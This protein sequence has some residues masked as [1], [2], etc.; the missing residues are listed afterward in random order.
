MANRRS[1]ELQ[2]A[3]TQAALEAYKTRKAATPV[4]PKDPTYRHLDGRRRQ[5]VN[6][7]RH[8]AVIEKRDADSIATKLAGESAE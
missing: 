4:G 1:L 3:S 8:L 7:L 5:V 2:L 6:R